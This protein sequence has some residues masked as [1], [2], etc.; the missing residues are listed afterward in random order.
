MTKLKRL[1]NKMEEAE[2]VAQLEWSACGADPSPSFIASDVAYEKAY[3]A[4]FKEL[5][6]Q[7]NND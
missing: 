3:N 4:Y 2:R 5:E 1:K 6:K 7:Q